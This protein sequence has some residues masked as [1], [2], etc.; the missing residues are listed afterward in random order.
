MTADEH[1]KLQQLRY[2]L[3]KSGF[4]AFEKSGTYFLYRE[5]GTTGRNHLVLTRTNVDRFVTDVKTAAQAS[6]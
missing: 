4:F 5:G 6:K 1:S 2:M 3:R